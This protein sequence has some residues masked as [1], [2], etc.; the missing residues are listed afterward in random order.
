MRHV[1][2]K[3]Q[4]GFKDFTRRM[5]DH[6]FAFEKVFNC[7]PHPGTINVKV[8]RAIAIQA[9]CTIPDPIDT[10]QILLIENCLINGIPGFRI[11]P[12]VIDNPTLGGHGDD[13]LEISSCHTIA[14]IAPEVEVT[15]EFFRVLPEMTL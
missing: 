1:K 5:T 12:S 10:R 7:V 9:D 2:G 3:V 11:R 6:R 15:I 8:D 13:I 14:G 4:T